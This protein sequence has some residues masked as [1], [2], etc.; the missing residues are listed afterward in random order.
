M[1]QWN[2]YILE[3]ERQGLV[4]EIRVEQLINKEE[5][6]EK[7]NNIKDS[8]SGLSLLNEQGKYKLNKFKI[9]KYLLY[10]SSVYCI[11]KKYIFIIVFF[12]KC[13]SINCYNNN[14][15]IQGYKKYI[16]NAGGIDTKVKIF[17]KQKSGI[18]LNLYY[19]NA[20]FLNLFNLSKL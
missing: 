3:T 19:I 5:V 16:A 7:E 1:L 20:K 17:G 18:I 11:L 4:E 2:T 15:L 13:R 8:E 6:T 14:N 9:K 12:K 10:Y